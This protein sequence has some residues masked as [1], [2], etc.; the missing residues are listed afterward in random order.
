MPLALNPQVD[1]PLGRLFSQMGK[2]YLHLL[3]AKLKHLDIDRYYYTLVVI[4]TYEGEI[5]QQELA[6][7]LD[8]DKVS[9]VR[10]VDYLSEK[11][12]V[13]RVQKND[14][15][16]KHN[17]MLTEKAKL[18][19]PEIIKSITEMNEKMLNGLSG[20]QHK[21][22]NESIEKIKNNLFVNTKTL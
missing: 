17:L 15:R 9:V 3:R 18:A 1:Q 2:G 10:M 21:E 14:D 7:T 19:I 16:R 13:R 8:T 12:Y 4:G 22:L 5:T 11:G 20:S 6:L